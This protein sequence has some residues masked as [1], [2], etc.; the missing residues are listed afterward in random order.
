MV[1]FAWNLASDI[2]DL[3]SRFVDSRPRPWRVVHSSGGGDFFQTGDVFFDRFVEAVDLQPSAHVLDMGCGAG[4]LARPICDYLDERGSYTG[5]DI[6]KS[7]IAFARRTISGRA[8]IAFHHADVSNREYRRAG[9]A[10]ARYRFPVDDGSVDAAIATSLFSHLMPDVARAYLAECARVL[11][12]GGQLMM[13]AFLVDEAAKAAF[14]S[15]S[16]RLPMLSMDDHSFAVD[17]RH[18]ERAIGFDEGTF[19]EWVQAS[20]LELSGDVQRGDWRLAARQGLD[21][22]DCLVLRRRSE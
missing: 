21:L 6:S 17:P 16:A 2:K 9:G 14:A 15:Q 12:P 11:R 13:T 8:A 20:G 19:L 1:I 22:Q 5:F 10:A 7:A 3:P 4:R 18:P